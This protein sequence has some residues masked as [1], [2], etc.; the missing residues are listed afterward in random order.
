MF[1]TPTRCKR[2]WLNRSWRTLPLRSFK[3][4][5]APL[6][7]PTRNPRSACWRV[8][9]IMF[10]WARPNTWRSPSFSLEPVLSIPSTPS[11]RHMHIYIAF[12]WEK[13]KKN[14]ILVEGFSYFIFLAFDFIL[15]PWEELAKFF[16]F[17]FLIVTIFLKGS[18]RRRVHDPSGTREARHKTRHAFE[19]GK[20]QI[21]IIYLFI[22]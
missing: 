22:V 8:W 3:E 17:L 6:T 11:S 5:L 2:K 15:G 18:R 21:Y 13:L 19:Q 4:K 16:S 10:L 20:A 7:Q 14:K 12:V 1:K 9:S